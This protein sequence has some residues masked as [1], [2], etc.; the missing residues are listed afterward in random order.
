M[1]IV[2]YK[3]IF[4]SLSIL[5]MIVSAVFI[6]TFGLRPGIDFKG[7]ALLEVTY[8]AGRPEISLIEDKVK[9]YEVLRFWDRVIG[10]SLPKAQGQ[11]MAL[12]FERGIL[13]VAV[14]SRDVASEIRMYSQRLIYALNVI[15]GREMVFAIVCEY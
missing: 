7:G 4:L 12:S 5:L 9:T 10:E 13:R 3:K 2:K 15:L 14:L 8:P 6:F 1:F 11:T